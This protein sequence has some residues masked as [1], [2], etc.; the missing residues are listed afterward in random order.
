[1]S[2]EIKAEKRK[3]ALSLLIEIPV[4]IRIV[5]LIRA[6]INPVIVSGESM[7]PTLHSGDLIIVSR[8][9][10]GL[11]RGD[12]V[13]CGVKDGLFTKKLVKRVIGLPGETITCRNGHIYVNDM[14]LDDYTNDEILDPG[15]LSKPVE[16]PE[17]EYFVLGDNRNHSADSRVYGCFAKSD[18]FGKMT[19]LICLNSR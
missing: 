6:V 4:I 14:S 3:A 18:I 10:D 16:V 9:T 1:M 5:F 17:G 11:E 2:G 15:L 12:I 19:K 7:E 8:S 13:V